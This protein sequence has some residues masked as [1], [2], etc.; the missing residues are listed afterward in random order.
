[1]NLNKNEISLRFNPLSSFRIIDC[2]DSTTF[3]LSGVGNDITF[4]FPKSTLE[5][6]RFA[7][8]GINNSLI[9]L[10]TLLFTVKKLLLPFENSFVRSLLFIPF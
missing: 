3:I 4:D 8:L 7:T 6:E 2:F 10:N 9:Q 5:E 1:M